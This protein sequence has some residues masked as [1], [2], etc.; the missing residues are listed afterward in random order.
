MD[1]PALGG[2]A[3]QSLE[4]DKYV[5]VM[6]CCLVFSACVHGNGPVPGDTCIVSCVQCVMCR[7]YSSVSS[8]GDPV[9]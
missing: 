8:S 4:S 9:F 6:R 3:E 7:S 5:T 1:G 2:A